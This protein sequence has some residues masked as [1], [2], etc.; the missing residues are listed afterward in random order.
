VD[1]E[2]GYVIIAVAGAAICW[3]VGRLVPGVRAGDA[4]APRLF[5]H[6]ETDP[7]LIHAGAPDWIGASFVMP[8][9]DLASA[10][11]PSGGGPLWRAW[12]RPLGAYDGGATKVRVSMHATSDTTVL[13]D[14]LLV[15]VIERADPTG[16]V[17][18]CLVGGAC[19]LTR[20]LQVD[21]DPEPCVVD[22]RDEFGDGAEPFAFTLSPGKVEVFHITA[23]TTRR[24]QWTAELRML[25]NGERRTEHLDD[26]GRP[27]RTSGIDGL[28]T[29]IWS[30][31]D[32]AWSTRATDQE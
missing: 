16:H 20:S 8:G 27:F 2:V 23:T 15:Q 12:L 6:A 19:I 22:H 11:P 13:I 25:V 31:R 9:D 29:S 30:D 24:C 4:V 17:L 10:P 1:P 14:E 32:H 18:Q 7:T 21:L 28:P 26:D 3:I 5:V